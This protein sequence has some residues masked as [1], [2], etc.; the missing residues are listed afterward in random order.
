MTDHPEREWVKWVSDAW[1]GCWVCVPTTEAPARSDL[2]KVT[3]EDW[4]KICLLM[5]LAPGGEL[6]GV[7]WRGHTG[8][9]QYLYKKG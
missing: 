6:A 8:S 4:R 2:Q 7:G 9:Y 5:M 3:P 1:T